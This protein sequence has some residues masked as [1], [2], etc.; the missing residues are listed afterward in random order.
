MKKERNRFVFSWGRAIRL[1]AAAAVAVAL[2]I[3]GLTF[4]PATGNP[5]PEKPGIIAMP[6]VLKVYA[7]EIESIEAEDLSHYELTDSK[8]FYQMITNPLISGRMCMPLTFRVPE[9]YFGKCEVTF[10]ISSDYEGF[11]QNTI[12]KNGESIMLD[13]RS[14]SDVMRTISSEVGDGGDFFLDIII[15][16]DGMIA[17]YG[18]VSFCF[19]G[20]VSYAYEFSTVCFPAVDGQ[21]QN[22]AIEYVLEQIDAYKQAK[23]PGEGAEYIR[24]VQSEKK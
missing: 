12:L 14:L 9:D 10:E 2:L 13:S 7:C 8:G 23:V 3:T 5:D 21:F 11:F 16:A 18:V 22:I 17:G 1:T 20:P 15:R 24:Q 6:G 19:C 4:W